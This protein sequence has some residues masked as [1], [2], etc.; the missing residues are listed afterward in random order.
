[1]SEPLRARE[2]LPKRPGMQ[3]GPWESPRERRRKA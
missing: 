2:C 1:M 3:A